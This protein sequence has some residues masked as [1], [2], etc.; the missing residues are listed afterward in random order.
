MRII[1]MGSP[2][3]SV[4]ILKELYEKHE[5]VAVYAQPP[6]PAGRGYKLT[7]CPVHKEAEKME[8]KVYTPY[9][10][11][12]SEE[13]QKFVAHKADIAIVVAYGLILP[14]VILEAPKFGCINIHASL[15]PRWRGA[16]PIQRAIEA[17]DKQTGITFM[18]MNEGLDT[19]DIFYK[20][21]MTI[22]KKETGGSLHDKL[23]N[24]GAQNINMLLSNLKSIKP[25]K[26][27]DN[28]ATYAH[29]LSRDESRI[30]W[31]K[32]AEELERRLRAF[33]PWPG[34]YT[35]YGDARI[36]ILNA[37]IEPYEHNQKSGILLDDNLLV[38]CKQKAL[39]ITQLQ[40]AGKKAMSAE[41]F[42]LGTSLKKGDK[43]L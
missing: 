39:R 22:D 23:S 27:D 33:T 12:S 3:F 24:M 11:R 18:Q 7:S 13:Q 8:L 14:K 10:L 1:F 28:K 15:L 38:A 31:Q 43:F 9:T 25:Q 36:R 20:I 17:G 26:Q 40:K 30:D 19:G 42:L 5:V 4:P 32:P 35:Q 6:K 2:D 34:C 16:S 41:A 37:V 29:K 21:E